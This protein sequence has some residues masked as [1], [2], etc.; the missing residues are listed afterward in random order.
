[1]TTFLSERTQGN[2]FFLEEIVHGL[3]EAGTLVGAPGGYRLA[4]S[5]GAIRVPPSVHAVLSARIDRLPDQDK[6]LLQSAAVVGKDVLF[7]LLEQVAEVRGEALRDT[8]GRLQQADFLYPTSFFPDLEYTFKH[9]LT[10]EVAYDG[11]LQDRRRALHSATLENLETLYPDRLIE[12]AERLLH[13]AVRGEVWSKAVTYGHRAA[14]RAYER[15]AYRQAAATGEQTLQALTRVPPH[16]SI[17]EMSVDVRTEMYDSLWALGADPKKLLDI[18]ETARTDAETLGDQH[19]LAK[20][21]ARLT[22]ATAMAGDHAG[23]VDYGE[24]ALGL[25]TENSELRAHVDFVLGQTYRNLGALRR[26]VMYHERAAR[27]HE[28]G[29]MPMAPL[30]RVQLGLS[31]AELGE[32]DRSIPLARAALALA[33]AAE[34]PYGLVAT[35]WNLGF[36][37]I[38]QGE[39]EQAIHDLGRGLTLG[40]ALNVPFHASLCSAYLGYAYVLTGRTREGLALLERAEPARGGA[41]AASQRYRLDAFR[42]EG[43]LQLGR[44]AEAQDLA[45]EALQNFRA[46]SQFWFEPWA[47]RLLAEIASRREPPDLESAVALYQEAMAVAEPRGARPLLVRCHLG[48]ARL[49]GR[50]GKSLDA[51]THFRAADAFLETMEMPTLRRTVKEELFT[52]DNQ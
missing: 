52:L 38:L 26:S 29:K 49:Y 11:I 47:V 13:H 1:L 33:E 41:G 27:F 45:R 16:P 15:C 31:L 17:L 32:F 50:V 14:V 10:H 9:A 46:A 48:L 36:I 4:D 25:T 39:L 23:S 34:H 37:R 24:R 20:V 21:L 22:Q 44:F 8:L 51:A 42:A 28:G 35:Y 3:A 18:L 12:W 7:P 30:S 2:P 43:L 5:V 40:T 19:G 6:R